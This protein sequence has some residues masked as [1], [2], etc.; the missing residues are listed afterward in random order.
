MNDVS[1]NKDGTFD[2]LSPSKTV[3]LANEKKKC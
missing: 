1:V 2:I 3:F